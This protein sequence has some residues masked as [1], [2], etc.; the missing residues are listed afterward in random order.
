M[1]PLFRMMLARPAVSQDPANP[2][3]DTTQDSPFQQAL[4]KA[5]TETSPPPRDAY[6]SLARAFVAGPDF[7]GEPAANPFNAQLAALAIALGKLEAAATVSHARVV[8][9]VQAAFGSPPEEVTKDPAVAAAGVRLRDSLVAI[10]L[11]QEEHGRPIEALANQIRDLELIAK[12]AADAR[13]PSTPADLQRYRRRSMLYPPLAGLTSVLSTAALDAQRRKQQAEAE[14]ERQKRIEVLL[15]THQD[16][17]RAID[18]LTGLGGEHFQ[19][20]V[21][22]PHDGSLPP[23]DLSSSGAV[24][25]EAAYFQR[26][27]DLNL[28]QFEGSVTSEPPAN[29][30]KLADASTASSATVLA[31]ELLTAAPRPVAGSPAFKPLTLA[32]VGFHLKAEAAD[33]LSTATRQVL[34]GR[35]VILDQKP[36]DQIVGSLQAEMQSIA[37]ELETL[38][39][40][41]YQRSVKRVGDTLVTISTPVSS[42]WAKIFVG[43]SFPAPVPLP[44][45]PATESIPHTR[46]QVAPAGIADLLIVR[47]QLVGY[48]GTDIAHI[49]NV[50]KGEGKVREH[51]RRDKIQQLTFQETEVTSSQE[52]E[53]QSTDRF[54]MTRETNATIKEDASL[55]AG[56]TLSGSYGPTVDFSA[57]AEGSASRSK[58]EAT[59]TAANYSQEVTQRSANKI[60]ER[61]LQRTSLQVTN[62]VTE[63]NTHTIDNTAGSGN[64]SGVYQWVNKVYQAQMFNYGLRVMFDFMVP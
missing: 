50:L 52:H 56:L 13:F 47:Q 10:K 44:P 51:K 1:E 37:S 60:T 9:A 59:R 55:K 49:E 48:E 14:A 46:G 61:V 32:D 29:G 2:S 64:I 19:A 41:A 58:E 15:S 23:P 62:E 20:T 17:A 33:V 26:L 54:E 7:I 11:L 35:K 18:E 31:T 38:P 43:G 57:S 28:K 4:A 40:Q 53:L 27:S 25:R 22:T 63:K 30:A 5:A 3:I 24:A 16:L 36:L 39:V 34:E 6:Q 45:E 21:Q 8:K 42:P 12:L